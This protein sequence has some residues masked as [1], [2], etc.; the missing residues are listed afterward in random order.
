MADNQILPV[1]AFWQSVACASNFDVEVTRPGRYV[2]ENPWGWIF[3]EVFGVYRIHRRKHGDGREVHGALQHRRAILRIA[4][5][6][7]RRC[8]SWLTHDGSETP[9]SFHRIHRPRL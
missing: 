3:Q 6:D 4:I 8:Q 5:N 9:V 1:P 2:D 7:C